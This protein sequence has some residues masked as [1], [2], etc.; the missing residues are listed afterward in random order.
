VQAG[1]AMETVGVNEQAPSSIS[2]LAKLP[3]RCFPSACIFHLTR[4]SCGHERWTSKPRVPRSHCLRCS[5]SRMLI[6]KQLG[7]RQIASPCLSLT[8]NPSRHQRPPAQA[9]TLPA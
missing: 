8:P 3:W 7:E 2:C 9:K 5:N 1:V 4:A 6:S